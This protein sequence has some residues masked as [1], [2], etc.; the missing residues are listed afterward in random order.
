MD[1]PSYRE[2]LYREGGALA[3]SGAVGS[4]ILLVFVDGARDGPWSTAL[5][6]AVVALLCAWLGPRSARRWTAR[7]EPVPGGRTL[8]GEPTPLWQLPSITAA[9]TLAVALPTGMWDA[10]LRVT[11]GC[12]LVGLAQACVMAPLVR[13]DERRRR[14]RYVRLPGSRILR[15]TR[16][17]FVDGPA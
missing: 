11:G 13:A 2:R 7:A 1:P 3:A 16:L 6:L 9:L 14:R 12:L 5:Q 10:G 17:G 15:G 8:S 4:V